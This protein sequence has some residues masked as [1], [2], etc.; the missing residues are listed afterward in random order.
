MIINYLN[1]LILMQ[2]VILETGALETPE[3]IR[4]ASLIAME[5]GA[6]FIK[7]ST[8]KWNVNA[9]PE[10]VYVMCSAIKEF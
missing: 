7:T 5:A 6:D 2:K 3:N 10:A 8:G 4:E 1:D 9:T